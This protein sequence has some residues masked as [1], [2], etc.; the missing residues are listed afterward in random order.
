MY[1]TKALNVKGNEGNKGN[2]DSL[3]IGRIEGVWLEDVNHVFGDVCPP[4]DQHV[5]HDQCIP[6]GF[7]MATLREN[8]F[9]CFAGYQLR[10]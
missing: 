9:Q 3:W 2:D 7:A 8:A 5:M 1:V 10:H 6:C 4:Q